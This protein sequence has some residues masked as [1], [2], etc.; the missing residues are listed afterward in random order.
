ML[1]DTKAEFLVVS[2]AVT[3]RPTYFVASEY[4]R[5]RQRLL[6]MGDRDSQ[7]KVKAVVHL[8][9]Q[10]IVAQA[11]NAEENESLVVDISVE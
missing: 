9:L 3:Q 4:F 1:T 2:A 5:Q 8:L 7:E 10:L 11:E 6:G